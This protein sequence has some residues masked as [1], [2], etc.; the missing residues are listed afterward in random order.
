MLPEIVGSTPVAIAS[1]AARAIRAATVAAMPQEACGLIFAEAG[2]ILSAS[3]A[4]NV[5]ESPRNRFEIDPAHLFAAHR[6]VRGST[7]R[8]A[9]CWH[10]HPNGR[11]TPSRHDAAGIGDAGWLWLIAADGVVR[12]FRPEAGTFRAVALAEADIAAVAP[13]LAGR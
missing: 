8:I 13:P 11:A 12:A 4:R 1:G 9:G 10:S 3:I 5:A 7:L 2:I 6:G